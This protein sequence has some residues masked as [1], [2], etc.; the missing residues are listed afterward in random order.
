MK[1]NQL[2]SV[3]LC[4]RVIVVRFVAKKEVCLMCW[5]WLPSLPSL[6]YQFT[7]FTIQA[8]PHRVYMWL[9]CL[10]VRSFVCAR[11]CVCVNVFLCLP[12]HIC[13]CASANDCTFSYHL[14]QWRVN[15]DWTKEKLNFMIMPFSC[16]C[17]RVA[18]VVVDSNLY[19][20]E[21]RWRSTFQY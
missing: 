18:S 11:T 20:S 13:M 2:C 6:V 17:V 16:L 5:L 12:L 9:M 3:C 19:I 10:F 4:V 15:D 7:G 21:A 8:I 14:T 1:S